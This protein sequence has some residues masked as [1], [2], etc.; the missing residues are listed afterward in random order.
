MT[1]VGI[2]AEYN[3]FHRGHAHQIEEIRKRYGADTR[4]IAVMSGNFPQRGDV[5]I[6][7]KYTR[8][9]A[10]VVGGVD[11]V[12]ELPFPF[13]GESAPVFAAAGVAILHALGT[14]D[15]LSFGAEENDV[16][17]LAKA[18]ETVSDGVFL[19]EIHAL[20]KHS[21]NGYPEVFYR[22]VAEKA[23]K[24]TADLFLVPNNL[25]GIEYIKESKKM[26]GENAPCLFY[27]I[28]FNIFSIKIP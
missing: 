8:A 15:V 16:S 19:E 25:L 24:D 28:E 14:V 20:S 23:G 2:I 17:R 12:L 5:A 26:T 13:C 18:A 22:T 11:L 10:A 1:T 7:D 3:P 4:I 27:P 6:A 21:E 9:K